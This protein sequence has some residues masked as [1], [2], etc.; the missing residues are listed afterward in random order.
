MVVVRSAECLRERVHYV[1]VGLVD[2][3]LKVSSPK[4]FSQAQVPDLQLFH[5][6]WSALGNDR[7]RCR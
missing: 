3:Q 2:T 6:G 4:T 5:P 1:V 7:A